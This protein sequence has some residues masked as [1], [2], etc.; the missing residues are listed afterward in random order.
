MI[1]LFA[2]YT[3][4]NLGGMYTGVFY[5]PLMRIH[6]PADY[7]GQVDVGHVCFHGFMVVCR[8]SQGVLRQPDADGF[9]KS[10]VGLSMVIGPF[11]VRMVAVN[12]EIADRWL[13]K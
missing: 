12:S 2:D 6:A 5:E 3:M 13:W 4:E 10:E 1:L 9:Q 7:A 11:G 8:Q